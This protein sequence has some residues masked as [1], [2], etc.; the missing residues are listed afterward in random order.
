MNGGDEQRSG[1]GSLILGGAARNV[2]VAML[3]T[4]VVFTTL[5]LIVINS[6]GWQKVKTTFFNPDEVRTYFGT[7]GH[8]FVL[9]INIFLVAEVLIL[10]LALG[11]AVLRTIPGPAF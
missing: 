7:I 11:L 8:A 4:L 5:V 9:N 10:A 3:S 1:R 2:S 6:P